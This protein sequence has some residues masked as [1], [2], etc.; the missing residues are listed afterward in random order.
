MH[1][2]FQKY[3][4]KSVKV[5]DT[6]EVVADS[7]ADYLQRHPEIE[8]RLT[9]AKSKTAKGSRTFLTTDDPKSLKA[10]AEKHLGAKIKMPE[11]VEL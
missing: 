11:K 2:D 5:F 4:G 1:R 9:R 10:F 8:K 6:G 7:L 3:M